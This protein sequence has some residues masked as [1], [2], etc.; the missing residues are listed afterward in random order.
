MALGRGLVALPLLQL[1][2]VAPGA[3]GPAP[4]AA[5]AATV[6]V[7]DRPRHQLS[8]HLFGAF[9]EELNFVGDGGL[10]AEQLRN[11]GFEALGRGN[12]G[13]LNYSRCTSWKWAPPPWAGESGSS[14]VHLFC[15]AVWALAATGG[16]RQCLACAI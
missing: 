4:P 1:L 8:P 3:A 9:I 12:L 6:T 15:A 7:T 2:A 10:F 5:A 11:P 13:E 16:S 14:F